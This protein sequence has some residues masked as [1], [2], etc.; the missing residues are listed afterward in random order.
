MDVFIKDN[1]TGRPLVGSL[2]PGDV[3]FPDFVTHPN[4]SI[5][6]RKCIQRFHRTIAFDGLWID[7]NEPTS[8]I[9]GSS[10]G[11]AN[12]Q[13]NNPPFSPVSYSPIYK[14]TLCL[15]ADHFRGKHYEHHNAYA[16]HEAIHTAN[17]LQHSIP[18]RRAFVLSR[19]SAPGTGAHAAVWMGDTFSTWESMNQSIIGM[20][21]FNLFGIP[22][23]GTD[24]CGFEGEVSEEL[25]LRWSQLGAFYPLSRNHNSNNAKTDQDPAAWSG[26]TTEAIRNVLLLRYSLLPYLYTLF[27]N[28]HMAGSTVVKPMFF[29]FPADRTTHNMHDQFLWGSHLL[30]T[31]IL[32]PFTE[33]RM[34]YFPKGRWYNVLDGFKPISD[35]RS[36]RW[37]KAE[38]PHDSIGLFLRGGGVIPWQTPGESTTEQMTKSFG[39]TVAMDTNGVADGS[40]FWDDGTDLRTIAD[41]KYCVVKFQVENDRLTIHLDKEGCT[42]LPTIARIDITGIQ[43]KIERVVVNDVPYATFVYSRRDSV[44]RITGLSIDLFSERQVIVQWSA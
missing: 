30:I 4:A 20:L 18:G 3:Y 12:N 34:V 8:F 25:C 2:W 24:I 14:H 26:N 40:L 16:H 38:I 35:D 42:A 41:K 31:P 33:S 11:C 29:E 15:D 7:E 36:N 27:F 44:L 1:R 37:L 13:L 21:D 28:A 43:Q 6:W 10:T 5:W 17:A 23:T 9:E 19:S 32:Q 39:I 22:W